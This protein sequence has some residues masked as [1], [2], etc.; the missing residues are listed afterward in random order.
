MHAIFF[1]TKRA[2]HGVLRITRRLLQRLGLTAARFDM[3]YAI[4]RSYGHSLRQSDLRRRLG[5]T[6]PTVSRMVTSLED[7][8]FLRRT[9]EDEDA[10]QRLVVLTALG[11]KCI[12]RAIRV[13]IKSGYA[14]L[15][16]ATAVTEDWFDWSST[17]H[18]TSELES[19]LRRVRECFRD[20]AT[21]YY[22]WHPDD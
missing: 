15:A 3:L 6:A 10:R 21:L 18:A 7:L 13:T 20:T 22:P 4:Q 16:V 5:V 12:R 8:G 1:G 14:E 17:F 11:L 9:R 2:F 19:A